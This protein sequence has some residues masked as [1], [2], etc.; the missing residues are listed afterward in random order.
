VQAEAENSRKLYSLHFWAV[1]EQRTR[2]SQNALQLLLPHFASCF[3]TEAVLQTAGAAAQQ[4][5][6]QPNQQPQP[7]QQQQQPNYQQQN[8]Q[9]QQ[10]PV[11]RERLQVLNAAALIGG[12]W[13]RTAESD[14]AA[15]QQLALQALAECF[16]QEVAE[17]VQEIVR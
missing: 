8:V 4:Q 6:Q 11:R 1:S 3:R 15:A 7:A 13:Q 5:Q 10:Q 9:Q 16:G 14:G 17:C 2:N 12:W